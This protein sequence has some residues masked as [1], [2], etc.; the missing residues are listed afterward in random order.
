[1]IA[2]N[3]KFT[4]DTPML[5]TKPLDPKIFATYIA[6]LRSKGAAQDE[7]DRATQRAQMAQDKA[8]AAEKTL[9]VYHRLPDGKTP[10]I[11]DYMIKGWAKDTCKVLWKIPGMVSSGIK[12][13]KQEIDGK[14]FVYGEYADDERYIPLHL[15]EGAEIDVLERPLRAQTMQGERVALCS[16]EIVPKGTWFTAK[17]VL[18]DNRMEKFLVEWLAYGKFRG[19]GSWRNASYGRFSHEILNRE[20]IGPEQPEDEG[21]KPAKTGKRGR[22]KKNSA[23][24]ET[25]A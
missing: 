23:N 6:S 1:M 24:D 13:Y 21:D 7:I 10:I 14:M 11:Y 20:V 25:D 16:S 18:M 22:P 19:I 2:L 9:T 17:I 8:D 12:A 4:L 3:V 15:P 5:G